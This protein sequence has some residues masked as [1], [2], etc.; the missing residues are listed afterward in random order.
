MPRCARPSCRRLI[1][2][3]DVLCHEH[4]LAAIYTFS[5]RN[6]LSG[7]D[8]ELQID[9]ERIKVAEIAFDP[10]PH[11]SPFFDDGGGDD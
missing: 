7:C 6:G 10:L 2:R 5:D 9:G 8:V 1:L 3:E 11:I 4:R